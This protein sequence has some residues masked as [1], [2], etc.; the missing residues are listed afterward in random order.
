LVPSAALVIATARGPAEKP[1]AVP[2]G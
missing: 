1:G 2:F